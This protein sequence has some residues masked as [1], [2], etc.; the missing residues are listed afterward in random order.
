MTCIW[1]VVIWL[2]CLYRFLWLSVDVRQHKLWSLWPAKY[3]IQQVKG[4]SNYVVTYLLDKDL[5]LSSSGSTSFGRLPLKNF[6]NN[7]IF[8]CPAMEILLNSSTQLSGMP[9][10]VLIVLF[11]FKHMYSILSLAECSRLWWRVSESSTKSSSA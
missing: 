4:I 7:F 2:H 3:G 9:D 1:I 6:T 8:S 5:G 10:T 11:W